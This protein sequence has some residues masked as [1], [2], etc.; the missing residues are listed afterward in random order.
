[1]QY[2]LF[3]PGGVWPSLKPRQGPHI[4]HPFSHG[5]AVDVAGVEGFD[6]GWTDRP[7]YES[8]TDE[9]ILKDPLP[10]LELSV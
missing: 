5:E 7:E 2:W 8:S 10:D 1:M 6:R 3:G 9:E 4:S